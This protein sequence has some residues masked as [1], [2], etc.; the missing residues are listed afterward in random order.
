MGC[1]ERKPARTAPQGLRRRPSPLVPSLRRACVASRRPRTRG[2]LSNGRPAKLPRRPSVHP[3]SHDGDKNAVSRPTTI[4]HEHVKYFSPQV[5]YYV[6]LAIVEIHMSD[7]EA[8]QA[9]VFGVLG[10]EPI[11]PVDL[12]DT[13]TVRGFRDV[14]R[15][16]RSP[17]EE[18]DV[19]D[20]FFRA[21]D[22]AE[23]Y[24]ARV[25]Q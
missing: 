7:S 3:F 17:S 9:G 14:W 1:L 8:A 16:R 25:E 6:V 11:Q 13:A 23:A 22:S 18:P 19:A 12:R 21:V 24:C 5:L 20:F 15:Y 2:R 10:E 4:G